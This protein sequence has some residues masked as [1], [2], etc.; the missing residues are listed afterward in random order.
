M[1]PFIYF[2][3]LRKMISSAQISHSLVTCP[4]HI[5]CVIS[6]SDGGKRFMAEEENG[7]D[8][9]PEDTLG[10]QCLRNAAAPWKTLFA[11]SS[12]ST[13]PL[14]DR[15]AQLAYQFYLHRGQMAG[16]DVDDWLAAEQIIL[17]QLA[18]TR[19]PP[20]DQ[21]NAKKEQ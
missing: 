8:Y 15:I 10:D 6:L 9:L 13:A 14:R 4:W 18:H 20:G 3:A 7:L 12:F 17:R 5:H 11:D 16:H 21:F 19:N 1:A 2:A